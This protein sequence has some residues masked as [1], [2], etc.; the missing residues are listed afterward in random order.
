MYSRYPGQTKPSLPLLDI[1]VRWIKYSLIGLFEIVSIV[2]IGVCWYTWF[3]KT[4]LVRYEW[5]TL[6]YSTEIKTTHF[7]FEGNNK[8]IHLMLLYWLCNTKIVCR[9]FLRCW[10]LIRLSECADVSSPIFFFSQKC[11]RVFKINRKVHVLSI[12]LT[13]SL[14]KIYSPTKEEN[15]LC[16]R[17]RSGKDYFVF[18]IYAWLLCSLSIYRAY[19]LLSTCLVPLR[20]FVLISPSV[21]LVRRL[22][23]DEIA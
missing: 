4:T 7:C 10:I 9:T 14:P 2:S 11:W 17:G 13:Q 1:S 18:R 15:N 5:V 21:V 12:V 19:F 3:Q 6:C 20:F 8:N 23:S 16:L 22:L